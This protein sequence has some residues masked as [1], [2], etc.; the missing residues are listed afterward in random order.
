MATLLVFTVGL[1]I[2][3]RLGLFSF[4]AAWALIC[5]L[6]FAG[7]FSEGYLQSFVHALEIGLALTAGF[8]LGLLGSY[9]LQRAPARFSFWLHNGRD[10]YRVLRRPQ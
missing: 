6:V 10:R 5:P 3:V 7:G 1:S 9:L 2:G 8:V 4:L